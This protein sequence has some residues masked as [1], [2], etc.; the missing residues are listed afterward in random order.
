M[1]RKAA[2]IE[3]PMMLPTLLKEENLLEIAE[4]DA[5]TTREV[6]RTILGILV[7]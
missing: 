2:D 6:I 7:D 5:A 1:R 4:D 3:V